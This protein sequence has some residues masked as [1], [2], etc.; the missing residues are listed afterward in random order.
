M[1]LADSLKPNV[2]QVD[3]SDP[4]FAH[5]VVHEGSEGP[6]EVKKSCM[7]GINECVVFILQNLRIYPYASLN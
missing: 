4:G 2:S 5:L 1:Q 3:N 6:C 7:C